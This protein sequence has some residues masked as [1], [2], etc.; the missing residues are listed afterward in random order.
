M[1]NYCSHVSVQHENMS[2]AMFDYMF[3]D[4]ANGLKEK[5]KEHGLDETDCFFIKE[6]IAGP[7]KDHGTNKSLQVGMKI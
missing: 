4:P 5:F 2:V 6:Q 3:N 1:R 7:Y